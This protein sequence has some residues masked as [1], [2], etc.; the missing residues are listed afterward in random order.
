MTLSQYFWAQF[1]KESYNNVVSL[2][3]FQLTFNEEQIITGYLIDGAMGSSGGGRVQKLS[4]VCLHNAIVARGFWLLILHCG[5]P[6][7]PQRHL[8]C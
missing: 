1:Q 8:Y 3:S 7:P 6:D 5:T 2:G 4:D